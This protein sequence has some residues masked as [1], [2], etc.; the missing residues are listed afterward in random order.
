MGLGHV[1]NGKRKTVGILLTIGALIAT[2]V[3]LQLKTTAP[4][5]YAYQTVVFLLLGSAL[6]G[7][8]Y[9]EAKSINGQS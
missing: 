9:R 1:Y 4:T 7:D 6:G 3:E 2:Y 8:A 5:L